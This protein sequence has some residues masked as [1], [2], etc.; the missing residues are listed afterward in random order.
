[1][2]L[3]HDPSISSYYVNDAFYRELVESFSDWQRDDL[4]VDDPAE[5]DRFRLLLEREA[6]SLD[7]LRFDEWL[8][9]YCPECVSGC[10][11]ARGGRS[12]ARDRHIVR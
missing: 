9:L 6:R 3:T 1:M 12:P 4:I 2:Q 8:A 10:G 7:Q 11:N 5:R